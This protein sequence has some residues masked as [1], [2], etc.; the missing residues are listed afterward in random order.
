MQDLIIV[1]N[2][3][4]RGPQPQLPTGT[5]GRVTSIGGQGEQLAPTA[6]FGAPCGL[7]ALPNAL[8]P[9]VHPECC[10]WAAERVSPLNAYLLCP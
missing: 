10:L 9:G 8:G 1:F 7:W 6:G 3:R 4:L 5:R 2:Y